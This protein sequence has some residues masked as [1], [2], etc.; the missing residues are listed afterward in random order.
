ME[1]LTSSMFA[2]IQRQLGL[3]LVS[4]KASVDYVVVDHVEKPG[5]N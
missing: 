1:W 2:D 5:E 4:D 3:Q